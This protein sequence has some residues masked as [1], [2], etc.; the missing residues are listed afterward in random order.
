MKINIKNPFKGDRYIPKKISYPFLIIWALVILVFSIDTG[1]KIADSKKVQPSQPEVEGVQMVTYQE[2]STLPIAT[3]TPLPTPSVTTY[4]PDPVIDCVFDKMSTQRMRRSV[5][6]SGT[7]CEIN[8]KWIFYSSK[9]KCV[10][11]QKAAQPTQQPNTVTAKKDPD[12]QG[13]IDSLNRQV[14]NNKFNSCMS[15]AQSESLSCFKEC[16]DKNTFNSNA[17]DA[18]Y[19]Y[20]DNYNSELYQQC[21]AERR[22]QNNECNNK[23]FEITKKCHQ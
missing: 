17:C 2:P 22:A 23:C 9:D 4:D 7:A 21:N 3:S 1:V 13:Q 19:L 20:G 15:Q 16:G 5:C 12:L 14:Q 6:V 11:D 18:A 10:Q 8:G